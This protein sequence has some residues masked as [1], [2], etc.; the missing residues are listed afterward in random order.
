MGNE[1]CDE[2]LERFLG[3]FV[4]KEDCQANRDRCQ[5][6]CQE[7]NKRLEEMMKILYGKVDKIIYLGIGTLLASL[8]IMLQKFV[9]K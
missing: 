9:L 1:R 8:G 2:C 4:S 3:R 5:S 7:D 6:H